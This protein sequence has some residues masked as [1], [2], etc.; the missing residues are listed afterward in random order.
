MKLINYVKLMRPKHFVKNALIFV[1]IM[2]SFN[3][4]NADMLLNV[5]I[6]FIGLC[7]AASGIY[8]VND[9]ADYEKDKTHPQKKARPI[10][11]GEI[12]KSAA[13]LFALFLFAAGFLLM[14]LFGGELALI[15]SVSY[16]FLNFAYSFA[17]KH[18][19][20]IDC[21]CIAAG[22]VL[23]VYIGGA[24]IGEFVAVSEWLFLTITAVSLFLA[25]GK[26]RGELLMVAS[27]SRKVIGEYNMDFL[28]GAVFACAGVSIVFYALWA[29]TS[30]SAMIYTV[31]L[32][33]FVILKYLLNVHNGISHGDPV[34]VIFDDKVLLLAIAVFGIISILF[35]YGGIS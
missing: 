7:L 6:C 21:F 19:A 3:L 32:V 8:A 23:R 14:Y 13:A 15:F 16:V 10:A 33:I 25:F 28:N 2:Y 11:S 20:I 24:V 17:L 5:V 26:R 31:P 35:L 12:K 34:T 18:F 27:D 29:L 4:T 1:P 30:V 22:F 9:I